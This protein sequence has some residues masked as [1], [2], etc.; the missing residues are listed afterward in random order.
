MN[1]LILRISSSA[2]TTTA[3]MLVGVAMVLAIPS[4]TKADP[5]PQPVPVVCPAEQ[6]NGACAGTCQ[7]AGEDCTPADLKFKD[8]TVK[9]ICICI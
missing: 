5:T 2:L 3:M 1:H 9:K 7:N 6:V 4:T 8:G